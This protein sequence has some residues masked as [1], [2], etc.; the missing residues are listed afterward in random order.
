MLQ[1]AH[2]SEEVRGLIGRIRRLVAEARELELGGS[3]ELL[4][5]NRSEISRLQDRLATLVKHELAH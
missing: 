4:E 2:T 3:R 5:A 1:Q